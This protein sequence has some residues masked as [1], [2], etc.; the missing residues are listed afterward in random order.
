MLRN[1]FC[2]LW[3]AIA[4]TAV[5]VCSGYLAEESAA[6]E[7]SIIERGSGAQAE[8]G[9]WARDFGSRFSGTQSL[10]SPSGD[11]FTPSSILEDGFL[12][13]LLI[14]FDSISQ[15]L[16]FV[17]GAWEGTR[18]GPFPS[19][20]V[21]EFEFNI[22][23]IPIAAINQ[24]VPTLV[25]PMPGQKIENGSTFEFGWDYVTSGEAPNRSRYTVIPQF[26][27]VSSGGTSVV[28]TP[29]PGASSSGSG[30]TGSGDRKFLRTRRNVP[31]ADQN[32]FLNSFEAAPAALP[33]DVALTLGSYSD[34]AEFVLPRNGVGLFYSREID[35]FFITLTVPEPSSIG[36]AILMAFSG[37]CM[38]RHRLSV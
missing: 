29:R 32:R 11:V 30:G 6:L 20:P 21:V 27:P 19:S 8:I 31:G 23:P 33:L 16:A 14:R 35:P 4:F 37:C 3:S 15:A 9:L 18:S 22:S 13:D 28:S 1:R 5:A 38:P 26:D 17:S 34:L 10:I 36:L 7:L 12:S 24:S 2:A 25:S